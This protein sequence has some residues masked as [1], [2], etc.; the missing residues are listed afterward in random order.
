MKNL[1]WDCEKDS[2]TMWYRVKLWELRGLGASTDSF[3]HIKW[4][5]NSSVYTYMAIGTY[6]YIPTLFSLYI[7]GIPIYKIMGWDTEIGSQ[8]YEKHKI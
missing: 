3:H 5:L 2:E 1:P 6:A 4:S 8:K 7:L